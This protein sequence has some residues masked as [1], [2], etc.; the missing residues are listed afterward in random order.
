ME[1]GIFFQHLV[2]NRVAKLAFCALV[3]GK[4]FYSPAA[5]PHPIL[6]G[7]PPKGGGG[8]GGG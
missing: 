5:H 2:W 1:Q 8:G 4:G 7:V 6:L 3:Q